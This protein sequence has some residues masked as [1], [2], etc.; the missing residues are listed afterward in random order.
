MCEHIWVCVCGSMYAI[1]REFVIQREENWQLVQCWSF[2][3]FHCHFSEPP[4]L[5]NR[6]RTPLPWDAKT[7]RILAAPQYVYALGGHLTVLS[8][9][10]LGYKISAV[11]L[12]Y[13][14][15][16]LSGWK[17]DDVRGKKVTGR[18]SC[19]SSVVL[20]ALSLVRYAESCFSLVM[21]N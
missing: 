8:F 4:P 13:L 3:T 1:L 10:S 16:L 12:T 18:A 17:R 21:A 14:M 20:I 5:E 6:G 9:S 7:I 2:L 15:G 11:M 19:S